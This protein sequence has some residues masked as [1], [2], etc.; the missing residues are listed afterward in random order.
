MMTNANRSL[1]V[2]GSCKMQVTDVLLMDRCEIFEPEISFSLD[3]RR[4]FKS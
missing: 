3:G 1:C 2:L 4:K